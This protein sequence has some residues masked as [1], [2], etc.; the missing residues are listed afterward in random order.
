LTSFKT[1]PDDDNSNNTHHTTTI[2][3]HS[4]IAE[5][6]KRIESE[7][8]SLYSEKLTSALA[9]N[10]IVQQ[11]PITI[12]FDWNSFN[13]LFTSL[14]NEGAQEVIETILDS[15]VSKDCAISLLSTLLAHCK[16]DEQQ[17]TNMF[18]ASVSSTHAPIVTKREQ[19]RSFLQ[20][21]FKKYVIKYSDDHREW[22]YYN[23]ET[24]CDVVEIDVTD[25]EEINWIFR[26][27]TKNIE[28]CTE[29]QQFIVENY[30]IPEYEQR[31][32]SCF[33]HDVRLVV[34]WDFIQYGSQD[35]AKAVYTIYHDRSAMVLEEI[36]KAF[37][38]ISTYED[39]NLADAIHFGLRT[40]G[41]ALQPGDLGIRK[42]FDLDEKNQTVTLRLCLEASEYTGVFR[43]ADLV[44]IFK[45]GGLYDTE[46]TPLFKMDLLNSAARTF[47]VARGDLTL[48]MQILA[49]EDLHWWDGTSESQRQFL[50]QQQGPV[51]DKETKK[52]LTEFK[53]LQDKERNAIEQCTKF[54]E[55]Y[56]KQRIELWNEQQKQKQKQQGFGSDDKNDS[57]IINEEDDLNLQDFEKVIKAWHVVKFNKQNLHQERFLLLTNRA[58]W[59]FKFDFIKNRVDEQHY[60]RHDLI[61]FQCCDIGDLEQT[62]QFS[63]QALK[64]FTKETRKKG[65]WGKKYIEVEAADTTKKRRKSTKLGLEYRKSLKVVTKQSEEV[66]FHKH[67]TYMLSQQGIDKKRVK[68][69]K[70]ERQHPSVENC[71]SSI[72]IPYGNKYSPKEIENILLE[73]A[74]CIF[75]AATARMGVRN[76]MSNDGWLSTTNLCNEP[77][78]GQ[79]LTRPKGS[80]SS[81]FYNALAIGIM[82]KQKGVRKTKYHRDDDSDT[83]SS[84]STPNS[85]QS[86][87][88][89]SN[90]DSESDSSLVGSV[91]P[92]SPATTG[93]GD[94]QV[95]VQICKK[96]R[97]NLQSVAKRG[98]LKQKAKKHNRNSSLSPA[99]PVV[100][101]SSPTS[102]DESSDNA[103]SSKK[104]KRRI[105]FKDKVNVFY[106]GDE[107]QEDVDDFYAVE[108]NMNDVFDESH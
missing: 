71:Y 16:E 42:D 17:K 38:W 86:G 107:D 80:L 93:G 55:Q 9:R 87:F 8:C 10:N 60:K 31:I 4:Y 54:I 48:I 46:L 21:N 97:P 82:K 92:S 72:F 2:M 27:V 89:Q 108:E 90:D 47:N 85:E 30:Y 70:Q 15:L 20:Q 12:E 43:A 101:P 102:A 83:G 68:K 104:Q 32:K 74:W 33:Q 36:L 25:Q 65:K 51:D 76:M 95:Q 52:R 13:D 53:E 6:I 14:I 84:V 26:D 106:T 56:Y 40:V 34:H 45:L 35:Y 62:E 1:Q 22:G 28:K 81:F 5:K 69:K 50:Q 11:T 105:I 67:L 61:E 100:T 7:V 19:I 103:D 99:T 88:A 18:R 66:S 59:T 73:I 41:I 79:K 63:I 57:L 96:H 78:T 44:P 58:Y 29:L 24:L 39:D 37:E 94:S 3:N 75:A 23:N 98:I 77:F 91:T 64:L 49:R